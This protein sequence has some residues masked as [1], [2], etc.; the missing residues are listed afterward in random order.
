M[1]PFFYREKDSD[2]KSIPQTGGE[3]IGKLEQL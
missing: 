1:Q 2:S 3:D